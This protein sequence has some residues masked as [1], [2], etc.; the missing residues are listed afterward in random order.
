M[1]SSSS[2]RTLTRS[3]SG[4]RST[5]NWQPAMVASIPSSLQHACGK[6]ARTEKSVKV[7]LSE[8]PSAATPPLSYPAGKRGQALLCDDTAR[9]CPPSG[10]SGKRC[11]SPFPARSVVQRKERLL[12]RRLASGKGPRPRCSIAAA[13]NLRPRG[14]RTTNSLRNRKGSTSSMRVSAERFMVWA[15]AS[16]P[17]GPPPNTRA[18]V[19]RYLRSWGSRPRVSMPCISRAARATGSEIRPSARLRA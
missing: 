5:S 17:T 9:P 4:P 15:T 12:A 6:A 16:T 19:S 8:S 2:F 13:V 18:I 10:R 3:Q 14:V 1:G 7:I 11:L